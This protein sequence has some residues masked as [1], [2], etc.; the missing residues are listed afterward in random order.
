[1]N[2]NSSSVIN[3]AKPWQIL[4]HVPKNISLKKQDQENKEN[5]LIDVITKYLNMK[6]KISTIH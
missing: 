6:K 1:M 4:D 3:R 5:I 2:E